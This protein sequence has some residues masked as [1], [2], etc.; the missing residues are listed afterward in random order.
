MILTACRPNYG[1]FGALRFG[2]HIHCALIFTFLD[3]RFFRVFFFTHDPKEQ[4]WFSDRSNWILHMVL[5]NEWFL[6]R[7]ICHVDGI[8]TYT[9][10][11]RQKKT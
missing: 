6:D 1:Y 4:E 10:T 2:N 5:K 11:Q 8:L 3:S 9:T 7:S